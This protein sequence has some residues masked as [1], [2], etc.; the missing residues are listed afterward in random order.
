MTTTI[1]LRPAGYGFVG[2][3]PPTT[4]IGG[5]AGTTGLQ[6]VTDGSDATY[7]IN[8]N[9]APTRNFYLLN[10]SAI[11]ADATINSLTGWIRC[12]HGPANGTS[13]FIYKRGAAAP[14][15]GPSHTDAALANYSCVIPEV[16][17]TLTDLG[18]YQIGIQ[19]QGV[20]ST[21]AGAYGA[22]VWLEVNYTATAPPPP[23]AKPR[24]VIL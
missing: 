9:A 8:K 1:I 10:I 18:Q 2:A 15:F 21:E 17:A 3:F 4:D 11:P 23:L 12:G 7:L 14:Q 13:T 19:L 5:P 22:E 20:E 16:P 24:T 6:A